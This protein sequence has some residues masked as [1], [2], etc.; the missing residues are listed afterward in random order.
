MPPKF[1]I[2][3]N[4]K[5]IVHFSYKRYLANYFKRAFN[6]EGINLVFV[7]RNKNDSI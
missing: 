7:F 5:E 1:L 4:D 3:V 2:F 6:L